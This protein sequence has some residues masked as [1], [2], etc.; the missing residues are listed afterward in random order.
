MFER[1]YSDRD[2]NSAS[3]SQYNPILLVARLEA[4]EAQSPKLSDDFMA[5][6][7][8]SNR[9]PR[10]S[11]ATTHTTVA[12]LLQ[13]IPPNSE[14]AIPNAESLC[15]ALEESHHQLQDKIRAFRTADTQLVLS[16]PKMEN[17]FA[18][19]LDLDLKSMGILASN[20]P[21]QQLIREEVESSM[22]DSN[23]KENADVNR[24]PP[25]LNIGKESKRATK[26]DSGRV[27]HSSSPASSKTRRPVSTRNGRPNNAP[28]KK[29][30]VVG[31]SSTPKFVPIQKSAFNRL[32]RNLKSRAGKLEALNELFRKTYDVLVEKKEPLSDVELIAATG[33][34]STERFDALRGL[35]VLKNTARGWELVVPKVSKRQHLR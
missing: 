28:V 17:D 14:D 26:P 24:K 10:E 30:A 11:L 7:D 27:K 25:K 1:A 3:S 18:T 34:V 33:E 21:A 15:E 22:K 23:A 9:I 20:S 2:P 19:D 12:A 8:E 4:L 32:P 5:L 35:S 13:L 31:D 29:Q 16:K 6:V